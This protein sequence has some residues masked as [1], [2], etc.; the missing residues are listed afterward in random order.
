MEDVG[1][2][3]IGVGR[4]IFKVVIFFLVLFEYGIICDVFVLSD[5]II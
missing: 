4:V 5:V 1:D 3:L 2:N